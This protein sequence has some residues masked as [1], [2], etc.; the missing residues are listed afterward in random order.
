VALCLAGENASPPSY[1]DIG[2]H[3]RTKKAKS[4]DLAFA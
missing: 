2:Q 1:A 4:N 3:G